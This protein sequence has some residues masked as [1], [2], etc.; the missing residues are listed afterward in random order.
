MSVDIRADDAKPSYAARE[1]RGTALSENIVHRLL[2][3]QRVGAISENA[4]AE[5]DRVMNCGSGASV[6]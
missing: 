1:V 5:V 3:L 6:V 4:L 2:S